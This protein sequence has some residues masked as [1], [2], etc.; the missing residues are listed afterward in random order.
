VESEELPG[1]Y[2]EHGIEHGVGVGQHGAWLI[3]RNQGI[4]HQVEQAILRAVDE[5]PDDA[6]N[7][8]GQ[9]IGEEEDRP[10]QRATGKI[11]TDEQGD[12]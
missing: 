2:R 7:N 10:E 6:R 1:D 9:H 8:L 3:S 11:A 12:P 5:D 4:Q